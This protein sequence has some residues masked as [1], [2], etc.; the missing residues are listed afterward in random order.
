[1]WVG[2]RLTLAF[3]SLTAWTVGSAFFV[4]ALPGYAPYAARSPQCVDLLDSLAAQS[5]A[6][7]LLMGVAIFSL[8]VR[9]LHYAWQGI[10]ALNAALIVACFVYSGTPYGLLCN[11]SMSGCLQVCLLP[12]FISSKGRKCAPL[13]VLL[14]VVTALLTAQSQPIAGVFLLGGILLIL[15]REYGLLFLASL[16]APIVGYLI[17]GHDLLNSTGRWGNWQL[18]LSQWR[19]TNPLVGLG[20]GTFP[21][22][23]IALTSSQPDK[24]TFAHSD[25]L[26]ILFEQGVIG[27]TLTLWCFCDV[28]QKAWQRKEQFVAVLL[29]GAWGIANMPLRFPLACLY[30][31]FILRWVYSDPTLRAFPE[32]RKPLSS[33]QV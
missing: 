3:G 8:P 13:G 33:C 1:M 4:Y 28:L 29:Y 12:L 31:M 25:W 19:L 11:P 18:V 32:I 20:T 17:A 6:Q 21:I 10:A 2:R 26:Q 22:W 30:G 9:T 23:G 14:M 5:L 16:L 27:L 7:T 15:A 24:W